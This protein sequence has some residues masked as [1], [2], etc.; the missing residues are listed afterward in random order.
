MSLARCCVVLTLPCS[1]RGSSTLS[2]ISGWRLKSGLRRLSCPG[3]PA[4]ITRERAPDLIP[5]KSAENSRRRVASFWLG[6][7]RDPGNSADWVLAGCVGGGTPKRWPMG[8][9][10]LCMVFIKGQPWKLCSSVHGVVVWIL[11]SIWPELVTSWNNISAVERW[12]PCFPIFR[13]PSCSY[14]SAKTNLFSRYSVFKLLLLAFEYIHIIMGTSYLQ[15]PISKFK[16]YFT[17]SVFTI[18][19]YY[20][21]LLK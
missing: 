10:G 3:A 16:I 13:D 19:T 20:L 14:G 8:L 21:Y 4:R 5:E 6:L 7:I 9:R 17:F 1:G 15:V 11:R 18:T 12:Q 2:D